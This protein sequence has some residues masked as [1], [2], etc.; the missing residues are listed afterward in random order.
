MMFEQKLKIGNDSIDLVFPSSLSAAV[1]LW[2]AVADAQK[3]GVNTRVFSKLSAAAIGLGLDRS[4]P[5]CESAPVYDIGS[6]DFITYG[7]QV[8]DW[9]GQNGGRWISVLNLGAAYLNW[10]GQEL[11]AEEEIVEVEDFTVATGAR[12]TA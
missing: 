2:F 3:G 9:V 12:Q 7:N 10:C 8:I 5:A 6:R 1:D 11:M 4:N